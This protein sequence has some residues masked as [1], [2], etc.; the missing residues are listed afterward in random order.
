MKEIAIAVVSLLVGAIV[1]PY[2]NWGIEKR[3]QKLAYKRE[4]ITSWRAMLADTRE[5]GERPHNKGYYWYRIEQHP[6]FTS[7][8][9]Q[10]KTET[11][12]EMRT[13]EQDHDCHLFLVKKVGEIE[14][15]W[16]LI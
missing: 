15:K 6:S 11:C 8:R 4:L 14:K 13:F 10:L 1:G 3:K 16:E 12:E 2:I 7:L 5:E 9:P